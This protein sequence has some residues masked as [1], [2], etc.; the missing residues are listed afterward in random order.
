M[1]M[2][3]LSAA[4]TVAVLFGAV[5][6]ARADEAAP[7]A[8][9]AAATPLNYV[10]AAATTTL[11]YQPNSGDSSGWQ[12]DIGPVVGYGR[13]VTPTVALELDV[14]P[15]FVRGDYVGF[16]LVPSAVWSFS[17][18]VYAAARFLVQVDPD[19]N[20]IVFPGI[21]GAYSFD[22]ITLT[23]ELNLSSNVGRGEPDF[24]VTLTPGVVYSF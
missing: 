17:A 24:G 23:L 18:H 6:S 21:G 16:Y 11:F 1:R 5:S 9:P 20:F 7:P 13:Y 14:G 12:H 22:K 8:A 4:V 3:W 2:P 15:S 10:T 19:A